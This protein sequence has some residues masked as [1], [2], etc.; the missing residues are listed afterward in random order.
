MYL[1]QNTSLD[2]V[3][4]AAEDLIKAVD[5]NK[6]ML[7]FDI[8]ATLLANENNEPCHAHL[9]Q[10]IKRIYDL[11]LQMALPIFLV[12]ARAET[13]DGRAF[14]TAQL[15]CLGLRNYAGLHMRPPVHTP[16]V[17]NISIYKMECRRQLVRDTGRFIFMNLGDQWSDHLV[18]TQAKM[19]TLDNY[20]TT[21]NVLFTPSVM[22]A[23][24]TWSL[25]IA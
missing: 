17:S 19:D 1:L 2:Y 8:D 7:V 5:A 11:A 18:C 12:T 24:S 10:P 23:Y 22:D 3:A 9:I 21:N 20:Y 13:V 25:K 6:Y 16:N 14:T 4:R 15:E